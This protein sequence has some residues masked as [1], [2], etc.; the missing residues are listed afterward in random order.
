MNNLKPTSILNGKAGEENV[1]HEFTK[2]FKNVYTPN[3]GHVDVSY[4]KEVGPR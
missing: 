3:N 1:R 4:S 2:H